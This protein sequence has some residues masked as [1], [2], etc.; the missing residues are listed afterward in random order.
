MLKNSGLALVVAAAFSLPGLATGQEEPQAQ[1]KERLE[2]T[3]VLLDVVVTDSAGN[4]IIG[5]SPEDFLVKDGD[6]QIAV[7][8]A[9]FYSNRR[10]V[11]SGQV[12]QRLGVPPEEVPTDRFF[13]LFFHDQRF[14]DPEL[15]DE[16]LDALRW[17]RRW[18]ETEVLANDFVAVLSYDHKLKVHQDF[19]TDRQLLLG[20]LNSV[21]KGKDPGSVWPSR[22]AAES[23]PSLRK[24]L[25]QGNELSRQ[26]RRI[27]S[28][29]EITAEAAGYII[30]RKNLL[31]FSFGFGKLNDFGTY[32]PDERYYP[33]TMQ[34]LNDNNVATYAISWF[35]NLGEGAPGQDVLENS[36]S[37]LAD[38]TGG[39]YFFNFVNFR[40][41]LRQIVED[42]N[43]YYLLSY[44][45]EHV[46]GEQGYQEV[47]VNT[48]N[49]E[50]MVRAR[51]G[52]RYGG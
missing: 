28:G 33:E 18:V 37:L 20:A 46:V 21:G 48:T 24:N 11:E 45:A 3:E 7:N 43:G 38:D 16:V 30:G 17:A 26:T 25:P 27:Y 5:L 50:F 39:R 14:E 10:F 4:V 13:I 41:P 40:D 44:T 47:E 36:L 2:V 51:K 22:V 31:L 19:T 49:P 35:K 15:T 52:Y 8:T 23:G 42:N 1:F 6:Q 34:A 12:A 29:L 32:I 9:T